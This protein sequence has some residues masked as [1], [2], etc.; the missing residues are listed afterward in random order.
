MKKRYWILPLMLMFSLMLPA[1]AIL[2]PAEEPEP[3]D[4]QPTPIVQVDPEYADE[5]QQAL[6]ALQ[7]H[8]PGAVVDYAV[9]E[10]DDGQ[11][12]WDLFFTLNDQLGQCEMR[13]DGFEIRRVT[14]YDMPLDGL[15]ASETMAVLM[16]EKGDIQI[17]GLELDHDD[18]RI[19]YEGEAS[20]GEKLY[21]FEISINGNIIEW[22][23]D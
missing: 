18:G 16:Q 10:R 21:E 1:Q 8:T 3:T 5:L 4:I 13:E 6:D 19:R 2:I 7:A 22:E 15:T 17:I 9:R 23:R 14:L 12:E 20:L 11:Y